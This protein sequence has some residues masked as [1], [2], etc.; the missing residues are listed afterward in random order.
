MIVFVDGENFRQNLTQLLLDTGAIE[1]KEDYF[2]YDIFGLLSDILGTKD[3][4]IRYYASEI[5]MPKGYE[6]SENILK[7]VAKIKEKMRRWVAMLKT[8]GIAY[9]KAGNL[10]VKDGK[11][12]HKCG[13]R[14]ELLQEKGVDVR[15]A[16][17]IYEESLHR[18]CRELAIVSSDT[19]LCPAYHKA[20]R[21]NVH[22]KY[23]CFAN[24]VN[25]G[26]SAVCDETI[27]ITATVATKYLLKG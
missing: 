21:R 13:A 20:K 14:N 19:D 10:K 8:Q 23:I 27:T 16:L 5:K 26:V 15:L 7:Q 25:L 4:D 17:D 18:S 3:L 1:D 11:D 6:P 12:C 24:R 9:I 2:H 22:L